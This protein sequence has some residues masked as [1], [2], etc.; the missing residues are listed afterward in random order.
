M[1]NLCYRLMLVLLFRDSLYTDCKFFDEQ[2]GALFG[3]FMC[4]SFNICEEITGLVYCYF[5][6]HNLQ[7]LLSSLYI[8]LY[9]IHMALLI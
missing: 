3:M 2:V 9:M 1:L 8:E 7:F 6:M 5:N 4:I